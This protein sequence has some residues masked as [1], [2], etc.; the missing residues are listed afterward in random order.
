MYR[1]SSPLR[2]N[3][4]FLRGG[5]VCTQTK[6]AKHS[7]YIDYHNRYSDGVIIK[8]I[9][10]GFFPQIL[11][12]RRRHEGY[13]TDVSLLVHPLR[14]D[15]RNQTDICNNHMRPSHSPDAILK[16][17]RPWCPGY[18]AG[19]NVQSEIEDSLSLLL[20]V[21]LSPP[22][23]L[24]L[25]IPIKISIIDK[26]RKRAGDDGKRETSHRAPPAPF[27][28]LP[29]LPTTQ[30]LPHNTKRPLRRREYR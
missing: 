15:G 26:N 30:K 28:F 5:G 25:G 21:D 12:I 3:R 17:E 22:Q 27:F 18:K 4:F 9:L 8:E 10:Q 2:K 11:Q 20:I 16:T 23:R 13:F 19:W 24:P 14:C 6:C 7:H 29:S 1:P